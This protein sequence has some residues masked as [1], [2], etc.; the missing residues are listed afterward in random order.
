VYIHAGKGVVWAD[1]A[2]ELLALAAYL[3]CGLSTSMGARGTIPEDHPRYFHIFDTP[4]I[5]TV[6]NEAD[7][8]LIVG[9]RLGEYDGWGMPPIWG[10]PDQQKTIQI[11]ADPYSIG[12]NRP[13]NL[14]I[15]ADAKQALLALIGAIEAKGATRAELF[16]IG[17]Y[18][19]MS[20]EREAQLLSYRQSPPKE[21]VNPAQM[22]AAA[23]NFFPRDAITVLDGGNIVLTSLAYYPILAPNSFLYSVKM[24][25]LGTGL[26]FAIGAKIADPQRPV[27]LITGD[28]ALGFCIM[29]ME[30]ALRL[31]AP[32]VVIVAVDKGWGMERPVFLMRGFTPDQFVGIDLSREL[33]YDLIAQ[34][35]GCFG[36]KVDDISQLPQALQRASESGKPALLHV[37]IDPSLNIKPPGMDNFRYLRTLWA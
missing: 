12:L 1:A 32:V 25:Y 14:G 34:G 35:M 17:P 21:G 27:C 11:D 3:N 28:G 22:A 16:D 29:E 5:T 13:V 7:V 26:P 20:A 33:R 23:R 8:I 9:S 31:N 36:E 10:D 24:G 15:V 18:R 30:T 4:A 19:A 2:Q 6:R 37:C